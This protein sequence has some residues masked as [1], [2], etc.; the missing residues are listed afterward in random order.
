MFALA[1]AARLAAVAW[2][3][4]GELERVGDAADYHAY[5][6]SLLERGRYENALGDRASRMPGYPLL[7]A[8]QYAT[9]G[10][11]PL[12]TEILQ[13]V[14]GSATCVLVVLVAQSLSPASWPLAAGGLAALS[15]DMIEPCARLLTEA[16]A[17][18]FLALA[19]FG[20]SRERELTARRAAW[21]GTAAAAAFLLRPEFLPW[22]VLAAVYA[23]RRAR[24]ACGAAFL[25]A[26]LAVGAVWAGRNAAVLGRPVVTTTAGSF[27]LYGWGAARTAEERLGGPRWERAPQSYGELARMDFYAGRARDFFER[28]PARLLAK[29]LALNAAILYY[30]FSPALDPTLLFAAPFALLGL[31]TALREA[32][33]RPAALTALYFTAVYSLAGVMIPRHREGFAPATILLAA[34]GLERLDERLG[35]RK[36]AVALSAWAAACLA[37]WAAA[38]V[39]RALALSVRDRALS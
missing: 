13:S 22:S 31:W 9:L 30:P 6:V 26:T 28:A 4:R 37:A 8:A 17:A 33:A 39:L 36:F 35:R 38:P 29:A 2:T 21:A 23:A 3:G 10:R 25:A 11:S 18:F 7:L 16:P 1:L 27:N 5:A 19:M 15:W 32:R 24:T 34:V 20:L 14:L 12:A